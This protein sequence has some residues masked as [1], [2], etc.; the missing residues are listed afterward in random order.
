[1]ITQ[2]YSHPRRYKNGEAT[3]LFKRYLCKDVQFFEFNAELSLEK[4]D[5]T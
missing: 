5:Q 2:T 3:Q 4:H 1:M